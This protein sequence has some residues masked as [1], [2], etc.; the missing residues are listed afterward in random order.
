MTKKERL[1]DWIEF[2]ISLEF[3]QRGMPTESFSDMLN[4]VYSDFEA[5]T[6]ENCKHYIAYHKACREEVIFYG[7]KKL[8]KDFGC[9]K[10]EQK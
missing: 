6:C 7:K 2:S 1:E 3:G 5:R 4:E 10:W 9:N 8:P